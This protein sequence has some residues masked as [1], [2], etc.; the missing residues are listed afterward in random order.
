[1]QRDDA[2]LAARI[3]LD[4]RTRH[5]VRGGQPFLAQPIDDQLVVMRIFGVTAVLIVPRAAR[6]VG[7]LGMH[8]GQRPLWNA[9]AIVVVEAPETLDLRELL[10]IQY[11]APVWTVALVPLK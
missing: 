2:H 7:A 3:L 4:Q 6:E 5:Q 1:A 9:V 8:A 11:L 10:G